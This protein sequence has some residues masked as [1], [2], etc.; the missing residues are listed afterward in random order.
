M[1]FLIISELNWIEQGNCIYSEKDFLRILQLFACT[2]SDAI[3]GY[4]LALASIQKRF[5]N[6][7][8]FRFGPKNISVGNTPLYYLFIF[9]YLQLA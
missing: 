3:Y 4:P 1:Y 7:T 2:V 5:L 8:R 6:S 9:I